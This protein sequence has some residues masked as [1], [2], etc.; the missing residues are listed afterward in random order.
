[1]T[2]APQPDPKKGLVKDLIYYLT[3]EED[4]AKYTKSFDRLATWVDNSLDQYKPELRR[5]LYPVFIHT[6]L[7]LVERGAPGEAAQLMNR[8]KK[9]FGD[10]AAHP[11]KMRKQLDDLQGISQKPQIATNRTAQAARS[12]R[13][14]VKLSTYSFELLTHFMQ[15]HRLALPLGIMNEHVNLQVVQG[16]PAKLEH[17]PEEEEVSLLTGH[18]QEDVS[19]TNQKPLLLGLLRV[20]VEEK[21]E[22][23]QAAKESPDIPEVDEDGKPLTKKARTALLRAAEKEKEKRLSA[24]SDR[25]EP[26]VPLPPMPEGLEAELLEDLESRI[27]LSDAALPSA[28]FYTFVNTHQSLNCV[29]FS[30]DGAMIAGGFAD[31]SVRVYDASKRAANGAKPQGDEAIVLRGHSR[32]VYGLDFSMDSRLLLSSSGDGTVRLWSTDLFANLVAYRG[33]TFPVW[34]VAMCGQG[35]YFA[36]VSADRTARVWS[37]ERAQPLRTLV[38]HHSDV[39][40]ARWHPNCHYVATGSHDRTVRLWDVRDGRSQRILVGHRAAITSLEFSSDGS[41]LYSGDE[42]GCMSA[43]DLS[44]AK[45][46]HHVPAAHSGPVWSLATS[47]GSSALL[48]SGGADNTLRLWSV[49]GSPAGQDGQPSSASGLKQLQSYPTKATPVF[50]VKFTRRNLLLGSGALTLRKK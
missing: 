11:S 49:S 27:S 43:W 26:Q 38:G 25:I 32:P 22:E 9:Q 37:T 29:S 42:D 2:L 34:D 23:L 14:P 10:N 33:H 17:E 6:F 16:K 24:A 35:H 1:M 41:T 12:M 47:H 31:S 3:A 8:Y 48:A 13:Y 5:I 20:M 7:E 30:S 39:S 40:M 50:A 46:L 28:V 21:F 44:Q 19:A 15:A 4:P 45:R 36:S 18:M